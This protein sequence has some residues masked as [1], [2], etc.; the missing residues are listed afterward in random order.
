VVSP[1]VNKEIIMKKEVTRK[2]NR[3]DGL[4]SSRG[5]VEITSEN[6]PLEKIEIEPKEFHFEFD[7]Q[8]GIR[9][10]NDGKNHYETIIEARNK[11][12]EWEHIPA[13][14][15]VSIEISVDLPIP[16]VKIERYILRKE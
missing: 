5:A 11:N 13:V 1:N 3:I 6:L 9:I 4:E 14:Q 12:G 15:S 10:I 16:K 8:N 2:L 7:G